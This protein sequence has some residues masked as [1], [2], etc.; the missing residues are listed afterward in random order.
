MC[1]YCSWC[2]VRS[3]YGAHLSP[4]AIIICRPSFQRKPTLHR[5]V[6]LSTAVDVILLD[7]ALRCSSVE[8]AFVFPKRALRLGRPVGGF[9]RLSP[10]LPRLPLL[11]RAA[12]VYRPLF[13]FSLSGRIFYWERRIARDCSRA[14]ATW[15]CSGQAVAL[16]S[17]WLV[18]G[19][20]LPG[21]HSRC[22]SLRCQ[23]LSFVFPLF[24]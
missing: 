13:N 11:F 1:Y 10:L 19:G 4:S 7:R 12:D 21:Q 17:L 9:S 5:P 8:A 16:G 15:C 2:W 18:H 22:C 24:F 20:F 23:N 3:A 6:C 14:L